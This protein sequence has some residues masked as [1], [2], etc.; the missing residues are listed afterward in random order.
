MLVGEYAVLAGGLAIAFPVKYRQCMEVTTIEGNGTIHWHS[1]DFEG[2]EW[3][4]CRFSTHQQLD[5]HPLCNVLLPIQKM[6]NIAIAENPSLLPENS[7]L[8]FRI[9]AS[10]RKEW[11]LGSSS[12]MI[13]NIAKWSGANPW[14][15]M[16]CSFPGSGYDVAVAFHNKALSYR[17][18]PEGRDIVFLPSIPPALAHYRVVFTGRKVNSRDSVAALQTRIP[19]LQD[20]VKELDALST[21]MLDNPTPAAFASALLDYEMILSNV[22]QIP[23]A[24]ENYPDYPGLIKSLGAWGGDALLVQYAAGDFERTFGKLHSQPFFEIAAPVAP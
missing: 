6:L 11:G 24:S 14:D 8:V 21:R 19:L 3:L 7:D 18:T 5:T 1:Y 2:I 9:K 10:F 12:A 22:L 20:H 15:L 4:K 13:A 23:R 17:L 16:H